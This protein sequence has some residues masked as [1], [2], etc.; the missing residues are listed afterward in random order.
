MELI[1]LIETSNKFLSVGIVEGKKL[2]YKLQYEAWQRQSEFTMV[3]IE[4][5]LKKTRHIAKELTGI[6]VSKGPGSYTGL[7][8][9]LT[10][11]KVMAYA[12]QIPLMALSSLQVLA[13]K[14]ENALVLMDARS[15]RA[16]VGHYTKGVATKQDCIMTIDEIKDEIKKNNYEVVGDTILLGKENEGIDIVSNMFNL[17]SVGEFVEDVNSIK[18]QYL[19]D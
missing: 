8:I 2:I 11:G 5:A 10:I 4:K 1:L 16:Y 12:L 3:E 13:G 19:K 14:K 7:R 9:A 18:P 17:I 6:V 15:N